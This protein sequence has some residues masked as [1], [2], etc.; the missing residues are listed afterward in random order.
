MKW[1]RMQKPLRDGMQVFRMSWGE[2]QY[3]MREEGVLMFFSPDFPNGTLCLLD[4]AEADADDWAATG[5]SGE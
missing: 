1:E 2:D 4:K 5:P 3:L